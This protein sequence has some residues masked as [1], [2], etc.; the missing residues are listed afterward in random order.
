MHHRYSPWRR[1]TTSCTLG[2]CL[3][4]NLAISAIS[5]PVVQQVGCTAL[6]PSRQMMSK[7]IR[8]AIKIQLIVNLLPHQLTTSCKFPLTHSE[9]DIYPVNAVTEQHRTLD[10]S[11]PGVIQLNRHKFHAAVRPNA[12]D[13]SRI[14]TSS[15]FN[16]TNLATI[17]K[18]L[19]EGHLEKN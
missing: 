19:P 13:A 3:R 4:V 11:Q 1:F 17:A 15:T 6:M 9:T 10:Q 18:T 7:P 12:P 5:G 14:A 8:L 16:A 2:L